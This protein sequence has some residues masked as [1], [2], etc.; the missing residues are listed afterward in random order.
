[1]RHIPL[2]ETLTN[3]WGPRMQRMR[4]RLRVGACDLRN[5]ASWYGGGGRRFFEDYWRELA[6]AHRWVFVIGCN[7][8]GTSLLQRLLESTGQVS[9]FPAEGQLYTRAVKRDRK[10][11]HSRV[12]SEYVEHLRMDG[13]DPLGQGP[14][15]LH[16]WL[17][18][19][20]RPIRPVIVEKTPAN[21]ARA[22]W[23]QRVFPD[24]CFIGLVRNGY[25]VSEGIRRKGRQ[26]LASAAGHWSEVNRMLTD[27]SGS[28]DRYLEVRYEEITGHPAA[29]LLRVGRFIGIGSAR[30]ES[31][32]GHGAEQARQAMSTVFGPVRDCNP[33]SLARLSADDVA[34]IRNRA[35][36][37]LDVFGYEPVPAG[38][39]LVEEVAACDLLM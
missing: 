38:S 37:M 24:A 15:L 10:R 21:T 30:L 8:S 33:E 26:P 13:N 19:L 9:T 27:L 31:L 2:T 35:G 36:E 28:L 12:W 5:A 29:A 1:M 3:D 22:E 18:N 39:P 6:G 11:G 16:D 7:N 32:A 4:R 17:N 14:R 20:P 34:V 23:L 25:A